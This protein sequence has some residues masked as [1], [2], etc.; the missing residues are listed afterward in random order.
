MHHTHLCQTLRTQRWRIPSLGLE[1]GYEWS[2]LWKKTIGTTF[3]TWNC[4]STRNSMLKSLALVQVRLAEKKPLS[5]ESETTV[6][7]REQQASEG[8]WACPRLSKW[9]THHLFCPIFFLIFPSSISEQAAHQNQ[10]RHIL[11]TQIPDP[12]PLLLEL[13]PWI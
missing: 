13:N 7:S 6:R 2:F 4:A 5:L 9:G 12:T 10:W 8:E 1:Y 11:E 3:L